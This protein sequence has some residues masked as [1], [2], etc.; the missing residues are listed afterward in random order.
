MHQAVANKIV[1]KLQPPLKSDDLANAM[2]EFLQNLAESLSIKG[3]IAGHIKVL[4]AEDGNYATFSC[5]KPGKV[6]KQ[7]SPS[8]DT[9]V[10]YEPEFSYN[11]IVY[12][13]SKDE[14]ANK[15]NKNIEQL[16]TSLL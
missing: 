10:F 15:V 6:T 2:I 1:L 14:L 4:I 13:I 16:S 5:T 3:I 12:G 11:V 8:W 9:A 7:I